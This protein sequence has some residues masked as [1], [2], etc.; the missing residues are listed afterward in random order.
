MGLQLGD[1]SDGSALLLPAGA[2]GFGL[3]A[4]FG[5]FFLDDFKPLAGG[6]IFLALK[7]GLLDL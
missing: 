2:Q 1:A 4:D 3:F 7:C 5:E 6:F